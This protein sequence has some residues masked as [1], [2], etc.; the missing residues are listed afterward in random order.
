MTRRGVCVLGLLAMLAATPAQAADWPTRT[1]TVVVPYAPGG[2]TDILA[3]LASKHLSEKF[4]QPFVIENRLGAGGSIGATYVANAAPDGYTLLFGSASQ[5]GVSPYIQKVGYEPDSF[6]PAS[7]FGTI[8]F[9]L[10]IKASLPAKTV[11][12]FVAYAKANP[13][14]LNYATAGSGA[15]S[16]LL[17]AGFGARAGIDIV[18]V[19]FKGS[20][21][22]TAALVQGTV[23]M[24]WTGV[25]DM[26]AQMTNENIRVLAIS[27]AKRLSSLPDI[28]S[29]SEFYPGFALD[30]WNGFFAPRGTP[31]EI[32]EKISQGTIE[33]AKQPD[34]GK[35]FVDLGID[36]KTTTPEELA[37]IIK[38]D[39]SVY[40]GLLKAA[41]LVPPVAN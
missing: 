18:H 15:T 21:Q 8:P 3:R 26:A 41:G 6:A 25:S 9:L 17:G 38:R 16:H 19:P 37:E 23:E 35:R 12:E 40:S 14:K 31:R 20:A 13:G 7:V 33:A 22:A 2:F 24:A 10:G 30:T 29:I 27:S 36:P 11:P 4:N 5:F 39:Q 1:V 28:P 32:V 34:I